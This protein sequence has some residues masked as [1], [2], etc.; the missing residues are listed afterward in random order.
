MSLEKWAI[1]STRTAVVSRDVYWMPID[2]STPRNVKVLAINRYECGVAQ[3]AEI[4]N[5]ENWF[6][7][8]FPLPRWPTNYSQTIESK[9]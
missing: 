3:I 1:N 5:K 6:T 9:K 4:R 2:E 7:H 8:W